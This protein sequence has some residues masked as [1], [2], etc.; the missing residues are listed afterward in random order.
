MTSHNFWFDQDGNPTNR[1]G[2]LAAFA[3]RLIATDF[4]DDIKVSTV[5]IGLDVGLAT[6]SK[7]PLLFETMVFGGSLDGEEWHWATKKE[8][9]KGHQWVCRQVRDPLGRVI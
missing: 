9:L 3:D 4:F 1:D 2:W 7:V 6:N 5:F 8:A